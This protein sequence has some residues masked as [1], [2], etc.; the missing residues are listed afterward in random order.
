[1][2]I[3]KPVFFFRNDDVRET[4]DT[5][6]IE[7]TNIFIKHN[8]PIIHAV[9]PANVSKEVVD[10]LVNLKKQYPALI[11]IIQH[12][13][14]HSINF[15]FKKHGR[16]FRGEFGGNLPY[17]ADLDKLRKGKELMDNLFDKYWTKVIS[18]PYGSFNTNTIQAANNLG[19]NAITSS[20]SY[21]KKR[22]V[23]D[24]IG[25]ILGANFLYG[26]KVC[27]HLKKRPHTNLFE[28]DTCV[29]PIKNY[30]NTEH[31]SITELNNKIQQ[32]TENTD[33]VGILL[34]HQF[35][36]NFLSDLEE[37][38]QVLKKENYEF[39]TFNKLIYEK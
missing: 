17:A 2:T 34:H 27:Y 26:R 15:H 29:N 7:L 23:L 22:R 25:Q 6:L 12:G 18:F 28:I 9:E 39:T 33:V 37:I 35:H 14:D 16:N 5:S 31:F 24:S 11:E 8:I 38:I 10:W 32:V 13:Y 20:V 4:L 3:R 30:K 1:M 36:Q 19:Y 21:D